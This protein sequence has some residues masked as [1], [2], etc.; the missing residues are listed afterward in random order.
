MLLLVHLY[1]THYEKLNIKYNICLLTFNA[2]N[3]HGTQ[4]LSEMLTTRNADYGLRSHEALTLSIL[5]TKWKSLGYHTFKVAAPKLWNS[6]P[7][8]VRSSSESKLKTRYF[9]IAYN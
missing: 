6:L 8:D 1:A 4:Y 7:E 3:G 5:W 9:S 2:L